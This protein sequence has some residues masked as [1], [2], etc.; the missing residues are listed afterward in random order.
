MDAEQKKRLVAAKLGELL[1]E[2]TLEAGEDRVAADLMDRGL[3]DT[4]APF[5]DGL[6]VRAGLERELRVRAGMPL[7]EQV[8]DEIMDDVDRVIDAFSSGEE[9]KGPVSR[10][11]RSTGLWG[12]SDYEG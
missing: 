3:W 5:V 11:H 8:I 10:T 2:G 6:T 4:I 12:G 1:R 7:S 9:K